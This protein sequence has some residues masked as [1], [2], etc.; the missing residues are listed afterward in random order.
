MMPNFHIKFH[1]NPKTLGVVKEEL[2]LKVK[3]WSLIIPTYR[4]WTIITHI[5]LHAHLHIQI[6]PNIPIKFH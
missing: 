4:Q 2:C 5:F 1:K 6:M 3:P